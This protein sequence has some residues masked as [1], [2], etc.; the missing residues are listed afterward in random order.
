MA[1]RDRLTVLHIADCHLDSGGRGDAERAFARLIDLAAVARIDALLIAGDLFDSARVSD[2]VVGWTAAQLNRL[3]CETVILPGNH[4][5]LLPGSPYEVHRLAERC[6]R[7]TVISDRDGECVQLASGRI[8][9]WGRPV[10]DHAPWFQPL[11][12]VPPR[13]ADCFAVVVAHGLVIDHDGEETVRGSPIYRSQIESAGWDYVALGHWPRYREVL[14]DP[15]A[16]YAGELAPGARHAG[17]A[18]LVTFE[19]GRARPTRWSL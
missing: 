9:V 8:V 13:P 18:V 17:S 4:D 2:A 3:A 12:G 7:T 16:I 10:V 5:A 11:A 14:S 19:R 6:S 15:P 1:E